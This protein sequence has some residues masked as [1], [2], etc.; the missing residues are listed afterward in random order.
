MR[1]RQQLLAMGH[2]NSVSRSASVQCLE[3]IKDGRQGFIKRQSETTRM[4]FF[5]FGNL[6]VPGQGQLSVP[7]LDNKKGQSASHGGSRK[8]NRCSPLLRLPSFF[9]SRPM[10]DNI[11]AHSPSNPFQHPKMSIAERNLQTELSAPFA[12]FKKSEPDR[13]FSINQT[14]QVRGLCISQIQVCRFPLA[15]IF[16]RSPFCSAGAA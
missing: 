13:A 14:S 11:P 1:L 8:E 6:G 4:K 16:V 2:D 15:S 9:T 7:S 3:F 10:L 5:I 12:G